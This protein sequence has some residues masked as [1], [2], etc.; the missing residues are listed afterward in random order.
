VNW[1][2][3]GM[4]IACVQH[5]GKTRPHSSNQAHAEARCNQTHPNPKAVKPKL[6]K[7]ARPGLEA[8]WQH[9]K[10]EVGTCSAGLA[11]AKRLQ[12]Y[13]ES[14]NSKGSV[15]HDLIDLQRH[16][17]IPDTVPFKIVHQFTAIPQPG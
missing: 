16:S 7:R 15:A 8:N 4:L 6:F 17:E 1:F 5:Y 14:L 2:A 12:V 13:Q 11:L 3:Q 10:F 9:D